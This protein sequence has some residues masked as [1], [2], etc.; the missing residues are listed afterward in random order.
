MIKH[1]TV[2]F[3]IA[4]LQLG[5][6]QEQA[7]LPEGMDWV[8]NTEDVK[9]GAIWVPEN[10]DA[11]EGK[12]IRI[13][14]L[15]IKS[16]DKA[17]LN[18]PVIYFS[19]GPGGNTLNPG[20][21]NFL[22]EQPILG[23]RDVILFDQRGIGYSSALPDMSFE[24]FDILAKDADFEEELTLTRAMIS[25]YR[26]K[27]REAGIQPQFYNSFQNARDVGMLFK[28][29]GYEQYN[30][31][32]G[33]Y[34]T[35]L[36]RVIQDMFPEYIHS[37]VLDSPAPLSSDFLLSR[38]ESYSL[39]LGRIFDYCN[40]SPE[41]NEQYPELKADYF[42]AINAL[43]QN[44]VE[45]SLNDSLKVVINAQDGIYLLR[46]LLYQNNARE[47]APE[48]IKAY[49]EGSGEVLNEVL[50][51]EYQLTGG[52]NLTMLLSVER[53]ENFN[54]EHTAEIIAE[55]Y[56]QHPLIPVKLGFFDAFYQAGM[57]WHAASLPIADRTFKISNLPSLILVNRFDPVTPPENGYLFKEK[58]SKGQ[59]LIL[60]EG[61]HGGGNQAC[62][63]AVIN[64]FMDNPSAPL[65][66]SCLNLFKQ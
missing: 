51:F 3:F 48:L 29:L 27:C 58:L 31:M 59:L 14:Y 35:R 20:M 57:E 66:T 10:H 53:Y 4:L 47:K 19:G 7:P 34:G 40:Q 39:A 25:K 41:C 8:P 61:G 56:K 42:K 26:D 13:S 24:A 63:N 1:I 33:S 46:R 60:D 18:Y 45:V 38:L 21:V 37:S 49:L 64:A 54:P 6:S 2:L 11:P 28:H 22:M 52:L 23:S 43:E 55:Q 9:A 15:V 16:G 32:G 50:Q 5:W 44:P 12:K 17:T 65:D 30:L 62:K 36:A